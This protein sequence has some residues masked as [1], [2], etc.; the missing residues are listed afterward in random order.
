MPPVEAALNGS[1]EIRF[2][3]LSISASLIAVFIPLLLMSGI[4]GACSES[5]P[6]R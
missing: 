2:T 4:I 1:A 5:L 3:V 6:S